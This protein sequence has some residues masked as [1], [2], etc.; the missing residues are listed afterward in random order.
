MQPEEQGNNMNN[1]QFVGA[2]QKQQS[3]NALPKVASYQ[4][5]WDPAK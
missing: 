1:T 3:A 5:Q 2:A 4:H